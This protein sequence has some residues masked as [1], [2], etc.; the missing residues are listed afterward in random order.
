VCVIVAVPCV[1]DG[2]AANEYP[3]HRTNPHG[4]KGAAVGDAD[5]GPDRYRDLSASD[6]YAR[7]AHRHA[8]ASYGHAKAGNPHGVR[9]GV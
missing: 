8:H 5:A 7:A 3:R 9:C 2:G 1:A 4:H 6:S